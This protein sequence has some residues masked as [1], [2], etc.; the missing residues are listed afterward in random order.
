MS[1]RDYS[2]IRS[3]SSSTVSAASRECDAVPPTVPGRVHC[4]GMEL[5]QRDPVTPARAQ[6]RRPIVRREHL[7]EERAAEQGE[8]RQVG[9]AVTAVRGG[10]DEHD[11]A[12]RPQHVPVPEIAVDPGRRLLV[13]E[14]ARRDRLGRQPDEPALCGG[15][16]PDLHGH[17]EV[18]EHP[19]AC[20][21]PAPRRLLGRGQGPPSD[22]ERSLPSVGAGAERTSARRVRTSQPR[23]ERPRRVGTRTGFVDPLELDASRR[24]RRDHDR[25]RTARGR[26]PGKAGRLGLE[27]ALWRIGASLHDGL[28]LP[29]VPVRVSHAR[30]E[31]PTRHP[32]PLRRRLSRRRSARGHDRARGRRHPSSTSTRDQRVRAG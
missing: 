14:H 15:R 13:V 3:A 7:L 6:W 18:W 19:V 21:E 28:H 23:A 26:E 29:S 11:A 30:A 12:G 20:V 24:D 1:R 16:V 31:A 32:R 17:V 5:V 22:E 9:L 27:E 8:H 25:P 10:V 4:E 2:R